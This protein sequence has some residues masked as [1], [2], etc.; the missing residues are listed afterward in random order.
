MAVQEA[1]GQEISDDG[2]AKGMQSLEEAEPKAAAM[3][4]NSHRSGRGG[5]CRWDWHRHFKSGG[6]RGVEG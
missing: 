4:E 3:G 5:R 6:R 1:D 2:K